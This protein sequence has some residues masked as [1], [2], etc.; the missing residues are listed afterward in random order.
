MFAF[1]FKMNEFKY[2]IETPRLFKSEVYTDDLEKAKDL[3]FEFGCDYESSWVRDNE[4]G[5]II[6]E[7]GNI[8]GLVAEGIV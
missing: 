8:M 5:E 7:T 1:C 3:S 2:T 6:D 4:T